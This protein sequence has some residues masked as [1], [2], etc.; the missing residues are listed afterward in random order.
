MYNQFQTGNCFLQVLADEDNSM[1]ALSR[2]VHSSIG[3]VM[4]LTKS[5]VPM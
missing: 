3:A 4:P 5:L 2:P 1:F